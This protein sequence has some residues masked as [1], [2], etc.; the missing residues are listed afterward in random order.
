M[1]AR[2][3]AVPRDRAEA[4][5]RWLK[6]RGWLSAEFGVARRAE[7]VFLPLT[8]DAAGPFPDG[9]EEQVEL[10]AQPIVARS[11]RD[12]LT[13]LS[14]TE[15]EELPR[16]FDVVGDIVLIRLTDRWSATAPQIGQALLRFVPG[17]RKVG[18]DHGVHGP[19]RRHSLQ[20]LAG[21]GSW[22]TTHREN[23]LSLSVDLARAYFSPRL[24]REHARV[25]ALVRS[26]ERVFDLCCGIGPFAL[27]IAR[28]AR[29]R[30]VLAADVNP[31]AIA[32]LQENAQRLG[33]SGRIH[34]EVADVREFVG[35]SGRAD[36]VVFNLPR[37]GIMYLTSVSAAVERGGTLHFYEVMERSEAASRP[38]Q[39]VALMPAP[40]E[41]RA[42]PPRVIHAYAPSAD[43]VAQTL[44]RGPAE[45]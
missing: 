15:R 22:R 2:V 25:A 20:P 29:A 7:T 36:R 13:G 14:P 30:E 31:D 37:E 42:E 41:W 16:S 32:L 26:G 3:L 5:R 44:R 21:Q 38:G 1:T 19:T 9:R 39:L 12:A 35:R 11:Y 18:W 10:A 23:G 17:A 8:E 6:E 33:V 40:S 34:A 24:A 45:G 43:L 27:T 4:T 28:D